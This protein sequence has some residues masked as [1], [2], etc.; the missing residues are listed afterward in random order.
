METVTLNPKPSVSKE[1]NRRIN[2]AASR[3]KLHK[4]VGPGSAA[5]PEL[6]PPGGPRP[7]PG[8]AAEVAL[9]G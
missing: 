3:S 2:K 9:L 5:A 8:F 7:S 4:A 1:S 6:K